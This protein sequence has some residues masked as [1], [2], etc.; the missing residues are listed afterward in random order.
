MTFGR[1]R[2]DPGSGLADG[3]E[4]PGFPRQLGASNLK[5]SAAR[6]MYTINISAAVRR[7]RVGSVAV[8]EDIDQ[9]DAAKGEGETDIRGR[10]V[11]FETL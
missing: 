6:V 7:R 5:R 10:R 11:Q 1:R 3:N 9:S 2:L 4:L 8:E